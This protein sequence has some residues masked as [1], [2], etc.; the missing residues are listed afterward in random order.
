MAS[1]NAPR[2]GSMAFYPRVR[3]R[4]ETPTIKAEGKEAKAL[5]FLVYKAGMVQAIGKNNHK[6]SPSF[7][8]DVI[9]PATIVECP[10]VK[11]LGLRAYIKDEIGYA[12]LGDVL[13]ENF[14]KELKRKMPKFGE[15]NKKNSEKKVK[16]KTKITD[17]E[18]KM[19]KIDYFTLLVYTQPKSID[20]KKTPDIVEINIGGNKEEQFN[21]GK[22]IIGKEISLEDLFEEGTFLDV[23]GVTKGKGFQGVIKRFNVKIQ[24]PKAKKRRIVGSISPWN[25]STVMF[26]VARPGQM[27]YQN[28][29][30][31]N[32]KLLKISDKLEEVNGNSGYSG[33]GK[34][35]GKYAIIAG[36]IPGPAKRCIAIRKSQR[37]IK[38]SG[39]H[40]ESVEKVLVK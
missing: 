31:H 13:A 3:S 36:S 27:G 38:K 8:Q 35:K 28:R 7:G 40:F 33:Y 21:Y 30:E 20:L 19:D 26:T 11:V 34:V 10:P 32:K 4:K 14:E 29:T 6:G 2:K 23:K 37:P 1:F 16:E 22:E 15:K 18:E 39:I 25:P 12:I 9:I 24:R 5:S 17:F